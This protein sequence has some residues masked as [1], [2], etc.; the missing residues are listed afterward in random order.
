MTSRPII[1]E[2]G[3]S[4]YIYELDLGVICYL[5]IGMEQKHDHITLQQQ[6]FRIFVF[7]LNPDELLLL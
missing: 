5:L 2:E 7:F 3:L 4:P 1:H 6:I